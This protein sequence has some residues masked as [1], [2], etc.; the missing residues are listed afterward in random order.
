[1]ALGISSKILTHFLPFPI[2]VLFVFLALLGLLLILLS[3]RLRLKMKHLVSRHF[4]R[5]HYDYRNAWKAFTTRTAALV[6]EKALCEAVVKMIA[7]MFDALSV[8]I[9]LADERRN[10]LRCGGST[11]FSGDQVENIPRL[12]NGSSALMRYLRHRPSLLDLED[13]VAIS[14]LELKPSHVDL[15]RKARIRYL[16]P[17][18]A[19][20]DLLGFMSL[21]DRV[22]GRPFSFE[23]SDLLGTI[24]DQVAVSLLNL[25]LSERLRQAGEMEA[26]QTIAAFFVHD[27]KNLASKL[28]MMLEN[29][30]KHFDKPAFRDDAL[31]LMSQSVDQINTICSRLSLLREKLEIRSVETDL[32]EV[33]TAMVTG[34]DCLPAGCLVEKLQPIPKVL[35]DPEQIQKVLFNLIL[36]AGDA[37]GEEGEILVTTGSRDGWVELSVSDN[38]CGISKAFMD[39]FLFRPFRTTKTRGTGIGLFQSKMIVEAHNG[40]IEVESQEGQGSTF[41]V[42]LPIGEK[43]K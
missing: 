15:F 36:N 2:R 32:N 42:L 4:R 41:R 23:E 30:P 13:S 28:S 16:L 19:G 40:V 21:D 8:S 14:T 26:F 38:G 43:G 31:R 18:A 1:M 22:K 24:A 29:L 9:W 11:V 37:V 3:D 6:E 25:K 20:N 39:Q 33:V 35:A 5:P 7:E 10:V 12:Q 34:L 17:L 27:L